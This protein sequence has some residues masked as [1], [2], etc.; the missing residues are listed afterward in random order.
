MSKTILWN[1]FSK[2]YFEFET[3]FRISNITIQEFFY[4]QKYI[5]ILGLIHSESEKYS[6][7]EI[8][9][10]E[11]LVIGSNG[12]IK[13]ESYKNTLF[14]INMILY[15]KID[16]YS[17]LEFEDS[18]DGI[19]ISESARY[20]AAF[21][22]KKEALEVWQQIKQING[23]SLIGKDYSE[24]VEA[25]RRTKETYTV[26]LRVTDLYPTSKQKKICSIQ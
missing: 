3:K 7:N 14:H 15:S 18:D 24:I 16:I 23:K 4:T 17:I 13:N 9:K 12:I 5:S 25:I 6:E 8:K 11:V 1:P 19:F 21:Y 10:I 26:D 2:W 22:D 20:G